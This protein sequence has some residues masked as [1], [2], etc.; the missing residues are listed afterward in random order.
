MKE[1]P[2]RRDEPVLNRYM[3]NQIVCMGLF[4]IF[5][6]VAFLKLPSISGLFRPAQDHIYL[7]TAF[8]ALFI[9]CGVFN[10]FNARTHRLNLLGHLSKNKSFLLIMLAVVAVQLLLIFFGGSLFRTAG[11]TWKEL[12]TVLWLSFLVVPADLLRKIFL[13]LARK[14]G[15][16]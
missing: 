15:N 5:L 2:K 1:R 14:K 16:V 7:M 3:L 9:F 10:S 4:T 11:L 13:R 12:Q 8:F 6:C